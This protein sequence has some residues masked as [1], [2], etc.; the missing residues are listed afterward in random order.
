MIREFK[1]EDLDKVMEIWLNSNIKAHKFISKEYWESNYNYVKEVLPKAIVY[2]YEEKN[3][4]V[5]FVGLENNYIA[6]I[7]VIE[8]M[9]SKGIG[10]LLLNKCKNIY[11]NLSLSV[12][13]KNNIAVDFYKKEGFTIN[14][15]EIDINTGEKEYLMTWTEK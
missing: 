12:Y 14:K 9:R 6:G 15:I 3:E 2:V 13:E 5:A 4:I 8:T 10:T 7:F 1:L 11:N